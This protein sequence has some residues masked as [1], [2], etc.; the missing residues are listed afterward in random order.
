MV[1]GQ[2]RQRIAEQKI[3]IVLLQAYGEGHQGEQDDPKGHQRFFCGGLIRS[4]VAK[5]DLLSDDRRAIAQRRR[6]WFKHPL[7]RFARVEAKIVFVEH[8]GIHGDVEHDSDQT[9]IIRKC[10][11]GYRN[12]PR[13]TGDVFLEDGMFDHPRLLFPQNLWARQLNSE[14]G[15]RPN[16]T[17]RGNKAWDSKMRNSWM[18]RCCFCR[19]NHE[20]RSQL[21]IQHGFHAME[22]HGSGH[23]DCSSP[24]LIDH[25]IGEAVADC[26]ST[27]DGLTERIE[28][29]P[30]SVIWSQPVTPC[31]SRT[32][33]LWTHSWSSVRV[34]R[35]LIFAFVLFLSL[36]AFSRTWACYL[37][38]YFVP[39][40][41]DGSVARILDHH[42]FSFGP[43]SLL[44]FISG[45]LELQ[46]LGILF[47]FIL[48][49]SPLGFSF[50]DL[51]CHIGLCFA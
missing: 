13:G 16:F 19:L 1:C 15:D 20:S 47:R 9:L 46:N 26:L 6:R 35:L 36:A 24:G 11:T 29:A 43:I 50:T 40:C 38:A 22:P 51:L 41:L 42:L 14:F 7:I 3:I 21:L 45:D 12:T 49:C 28:R 32:G 8:L 23:R 10:D 30:A 48:Q 17:N 33:G 4:A 2:V 25:A 34:V 5:S 18:T 27:H 39:K 37:G 44:S 31:M